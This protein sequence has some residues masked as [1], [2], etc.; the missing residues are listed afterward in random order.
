MKHRNN[1]LNKWLL[2]AQSEIIMAKH[3]LY[4]LVH[5]IGKIYKKCELCVK[6]Y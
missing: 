6:T 3:K 4:C 5:M 1:E 2:V